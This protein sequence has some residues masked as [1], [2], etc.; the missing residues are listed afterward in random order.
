M[1][2][3]STPAAI[4]AGYATQDESGPLLLDWDEH[5]LVVYFKPERPE[6]RFSPLVLYPEKKTATGAGASKKQPLVRA[7][8]LTLGPSNNMWVGDLTAGL[9]EDSW[10]M[11]AW[12]CR[13]DAWERQP[14]LAQLQAQALTRLHTTAL[15]AIA[16][17]MTLHR[18]AALDILTHWSGT[19]PDVWYID[20]MYPH[21]G[22]RKTAAKRDMVYLRYLSGNDDDADQLL[23]PARQLAKRVVVKRPAHADFLNG[24]KPSHQVVGKSHRFDVY[25][26]T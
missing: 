12:G 2:W 24:V 18:G 3:T 21:H 20:P 15:H 13:V 6:G 9:L 11:A 19:V 16:E 4:A 25:I 10:L 7:L 5:G 17:R 8:G 22:K 1:T 23:D 26:Q 14:I